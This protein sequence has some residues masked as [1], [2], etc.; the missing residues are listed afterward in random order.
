MSKV[1]VNG[2][3]YRGFQVSEN[4]SKKLKL[5]LTD[6]KSLAKST[7]NVGYFE[8]SMIRSIDPN[9]NIQDV[10]EENNE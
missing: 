2:K 8:R 10:E 9:A 3:Y 4:E 7:V 6:D 1:K 5:W